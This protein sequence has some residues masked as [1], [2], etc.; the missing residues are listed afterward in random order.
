MAGV[1]EEDAADAYVS[2]N[3]EDDEDGGDSAAAAEPTSPPTRALTPAKLPETV[4]AAAAGAGAGVAA[5]GHTAAVAAAA[6]DP[7]ASLTELKALAARVGVLDL[8]G[9]KGHKRAGRGPSA[10]GFLPMKANNHGAQNISTG[11]Q[12]SSSSTILFHTPGKGPAPAQDADS[13]TNPAKRANTTVR[14][15]SASAAYEALYHIL[16]LFFIVLENE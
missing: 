3:D 6:A 1:D 8:P 2:S 15:N 10:F 14:I 11:T 7:G 9:N 5:L 16:L 4:A 13:S 12:S